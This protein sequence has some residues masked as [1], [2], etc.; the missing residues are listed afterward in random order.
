MSK[1]AQLA[2]L[3]AERAKAAIGASLEDAIPANRLALKLAELAKSRRGATIDLPSV[4][5][6]VLKLLSLRLKRTLEPSPPPTVTP[7][8]V[9]APTK[10][11]DPEPVTISLDIVTDSSL[12]TSHQIF[13]L[14]R[15]EPLPK[16]MRFSLITN[17][18]LSPE[19]VKQIANNFNSP[20]PDDV[21]EQAQQTAFDKVAA[22]SLSEKK[23]KSTKNTKPFKILD[24]AHELATNP[25]Y[26]K[27][28]RS[29]VV[30]GHVDAGKLTLMGRLLYDY[31][32]VDSRTVNKLV[33]EAERAGKGSFAL[34]WIMDQS[35]E[36]RSHG[37]TVDICATDLI[38]ASTKFTAI[39]APGHRDFVPQMIGGVSQAELALLVV[40][41]ITGEFEAGF[42]LDG[43]TKEHAILA[44][45]LGIE[46]ICVAINKMDKEDWNQAR[47]NQMK[48]Q[49]LDF[50]CGEDVGFDTSQ[51]DFI[52]ISGLTGTNVV[53]RG[54]VSELSWYEGPTLGEYLES[55][56]LSTDIHSAQDLLNQ[57]FFMTVHDCKREK[58]FLKVKGKISSGVIQA[59]ETIVALPLNETLQ[60]QSLK[61]AEAHVD[62]AISGELAELTFKASQLE[63]EASELRIGDLIT[64]PDSS[65]QL[66]TKMQ[67][68]IHLFNLTKPLVVGQP[69]VLFR[70]NS[71]QP[72]R[73]TSILE[74]NNGKKKK[75]LLHLSSKQDAIVEI[76]LQDGKLPCT[77][78]ADN[79]VLGRVVLR[80]EGTT[81]GAG[82]IEKL[83]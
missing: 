54:D 36:E 79:K 22:L 33:K 55:T 48:E 63:Q 15:T 13:Q 41:A 37:V 17:H 34:A 2:K 10:S 47:F 67:V 83:V 14:G 38:T 73:I 60:I 4:P 56:P 50:L 59:G 64:K 49:L 8:V 27:P 45:N 72:A 78:Y 69:F 39:D 6:S 35:S 5:K 68:S 23:A 82:H 44:K 24:L 16:R 62:L 53:K 19:K 66:V 61:V 71:H 57:E 51:V 7:E 9:M 70:N 20:L 75:K 40:D 46:R 77:T 1:L 21:V 80:R 32:I 81:I 29:F 76:E 12:L 58:G 18:E 25:V 43:Q 11:I 28:H 30:I 52:P 26:S 74:V 65:A 42:A 3:R 31:G